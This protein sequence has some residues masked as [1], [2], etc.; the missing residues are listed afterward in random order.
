MLRRT[1]ARVPLIA[2]V[3]VAVS[4]IAALTMSVRSY[5]AQPPATQAGVSQSAVALAASIATSMSSIA[6]NRRGRYRLDGVTLYIQYDDGSSEARII[7]T[8]PSDPKA[9]IWLDGIGYT[10]AGKR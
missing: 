4:I 7:V 1:C 6:P 9:A 5:S 10:R 3:I 2:A 8:N